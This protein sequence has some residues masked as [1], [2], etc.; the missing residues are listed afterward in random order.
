MRW[1]WQKKKPGL[2]FMGDLMKL[3]VSPGDVFV[4]MPK[5][6]ISEATAEALRIVWEEHF[7]DDSPLVVLEEGMRIGVLSPDRAAAAQKQIEEIESASEAIDQFA[8]RG[9]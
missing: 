1:P 7:G 6:P 3:N 2:S 4:V 5:R 8:K 9:A